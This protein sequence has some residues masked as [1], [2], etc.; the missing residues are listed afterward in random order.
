[1]S[2]DWTHVCLWNWVLPRKPSSHLLQLF[3]PLR[4][5]SFRKKYP[6]P[7][8]PKSQKSLLRNLSRRSAHSNDC[9]QL[10]IGP[11]E[12]GRKGENSR[13]ALRRCVTERKEKQNVRRKFERWMQEKLCVASPTYGYYVQ[14]GWLITHLRNIS[15]ARSSV[16]TVAPPVDNCNLLL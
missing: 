7:R 4:N 10:G 5:G 13:R 16:S 3:G 14:G 8:M 12:W 11:L 2:T 15:R 6:E 9:N 1:M